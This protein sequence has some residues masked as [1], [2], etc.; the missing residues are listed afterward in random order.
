MEKD[1]HPSR[2]AEVAAALID[3]LDRTLYRMLSWK[4]DLGLLIFWMASLFILWMM[5]PK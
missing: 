2:A 1:R 3:W 5:S 4:E